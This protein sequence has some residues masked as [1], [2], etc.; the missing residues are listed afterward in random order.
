M[1][2]ELPTIK[3]TNDKKKTKEEFNKLFNISEDDNLQN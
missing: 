2:E 3:I 1:I